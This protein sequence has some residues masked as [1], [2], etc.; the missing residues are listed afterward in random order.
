MLVMYRIFEEKNNLP[1]T[2]FHGVNGSRC[3]P[4]DEWVDAEVKEV[5]D[6]VKTRATKYT[7]GFHVLPTIE[8]VK[9]FLSRFKKLDN[10]VICPVEVE[11]I[12]SKEHSHAPVKLAR[13]MRVPKKFWEMRISCLQ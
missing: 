10:R 13:R 11:D 4:L 6:G 1:H 12:W 2:L 8:L 7:A 5:Y 9:K 3:L